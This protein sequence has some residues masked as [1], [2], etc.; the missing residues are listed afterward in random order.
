MQE[1]NA[2]STQSVRGA[3]TPCTGAT[4]ASPPLT[5]PSTPGPDLRGGLGKQEAEGRRAKALALPS[6]LLGH[7]GVRVCTTAFR[8]AS[9]TRV[10]GKNIF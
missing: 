9:W 1:D 7:G 6:P 10:H 4:L 8:V 3:L 2:T 5:R